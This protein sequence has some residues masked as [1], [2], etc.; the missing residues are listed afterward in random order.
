MPTTPGSKT[1]KVMLEVPEDFIDVESPTLWASLTIRD[2]FRRR[3]LEKAVDEYLKSAVMPKITI[4]EKDLRNAVIEK[5]A[6]RAIEK[7]MV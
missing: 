3:I 6:E 5:M 1:I 4:T 2:E 7:S